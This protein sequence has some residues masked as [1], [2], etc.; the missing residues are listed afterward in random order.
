MDGSGVSSVEGLNKFSY[1]SFGDLPVSLL[2]DFSD[3]SVEYSATCK[4]WKSM[5]KDILQTYEGSD[6]D[7]VMAENSSKEET[8][9]KQKNSTVEQNNKGEDD[10]SIRKGR[11]IK[12]QVTTESSSKEETPSKHWNRIIEQNNKSENDMS[13]REGRRKKLQ[14]V[15]LDKGTS[16]QSNVAR[17]GPCTRSTS[18][19]KNSRNK[20]EERISLTRAG[21]TVFN[22]TET[23]RKLKLRNR[24]VEVHI[25]LQ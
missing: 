3:S 11:T 18:R 17:Q 2:R 16:S 8:P 19:S 7:K 4:L 24:F 12:N 21:K 13:I 5:F 23:T 22:A 6:K 25:A 20:Q 14:K 9:S 1:K 10:I 15:A